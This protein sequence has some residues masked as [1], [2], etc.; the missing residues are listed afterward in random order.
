MRPEKASVGLELFV[1]L[2]IHAGDNGA[3]VG[4]PGLVTSWVARDI[5][6]K[7]RSVWLDHQRN[8]LACDAAS[9]IAGDD[10]AGERV[11]YGDAVHQACGRRIKDL[12][13]ED[14]PPE[15]IGADL[16]T[17][18]QRAEVALLEGIDGRSIAEA[19]ENAGAELQIVQIEEEE[20]LVTPVVNLRD[21]YR[22]SRCESERI[23]SLL[24]RL[25]R[26]KPSGIEGIVG[27]VLVE[28]AMKILGTGLGGVLN[29]PAARVAVL[30]R[31]ARSG[32]LHFAHA[33]DGRRALVTLV[34]A[35]GITEGHAIEEVLHGGVLA[36]VQARLELAAAEHG[37]AVGLHWVVA[38]LQLQ[39]RLGEPD[40]STHDDGQIL[41]VSGIDYMGDIGVGRA[42]D[43]R[44]GRYR[45][46]V[47]NLPESQRDV[48]PE[49]LAAYQPDPGSNGSLEPRHFHSN[50][51]G[52]EDQ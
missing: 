21:V 32:D 22:T 7:T 48:L 33:L 29:G 1:P 50:R 2:M 37:V 9:H 45:Y 40:I 46:L 42:E 49:D 39:Q 23:T 26:K 15:S 28:T 20:R 25:R 3:E 51:V 38:W 34:V 24:R 5:Q 43:L 18:K 47:R 11:A 52:A 31:V 10:I 12:P 30:S 27:K 35:G 16:A 36:T 8:Q 14:R 41:V 6:G 19:G 4:N 44:R 13:L 17:S